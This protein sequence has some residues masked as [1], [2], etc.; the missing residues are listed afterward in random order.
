MYLTL[1]CS[2]DNSTPASL[3]AL[4]SS[5]N[6]IFLRMALIFFSLSVG[7][8]SSIGGVGG[9]A[10]FVCSTIAGGAGT[11]FEFWEDF[12][13]LLLP[14]E[15]SKDILQSNATFSRDVKNIGN[16]FFVFEVYWLDEVRLLA[17]YII[18]QTPNENKNCLFQSVMISCFSGSNIYC[19]WIIVIVFTVPAVK[20]YL[21]KKQLK[22]KELSFFGIMSKDY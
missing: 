21:Y 16:R 22:I 9:G 18:S 2:A 8:S 12:V 15:I 4:T 14:S 10:D 7:V 1:T 19:T 20:K 13:A 5:I 17:N 11:A 3:L 6:R